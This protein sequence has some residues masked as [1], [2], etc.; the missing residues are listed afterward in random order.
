MDKKYIKNFK[1]QLEEQ[2][3]AEE[4]ERERYIK[5]LAAE[6]EKLIKQREEEKATYDTLV[7]KAQQFDIIKQEY[8]NMKQKLEMYESFIN[9]D[10][11]NIEQY[12]D[13][14]FPQ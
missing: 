3:V 13:P 11:R 12:N 8:D 10:W 5:K 2:N 9:D 14:L 6:T 4:N 1:D 7:Y